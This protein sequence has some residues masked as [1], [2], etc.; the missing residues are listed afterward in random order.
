MKKIV[1]TGGAGR[2]GHLAIREL[3]THGYEVIAVDRVHPQTPPCRFLPVE[4]TDFAAVY[5]VLRQADAVLHLGA[6]PGPRS[7]PDRQP[8]TTTSFTHTTWPLP[9]SGSGSRKLSSLRLSSPSD[10]SQNPKDTG[11]NTSR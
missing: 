9:R 1:V 7:H 2:L 8:S 4:L 5:D 11:R 6:I 3:L 10:G